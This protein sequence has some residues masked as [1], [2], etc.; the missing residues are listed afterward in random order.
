MKP[1][2]VIWH[3]SLNGAVCLQKKINPSGSLWSSSGSALAALCLSCAGG[4][5]PRCSTPDRA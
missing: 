5:M 3:R 4:T 2:E 1:R